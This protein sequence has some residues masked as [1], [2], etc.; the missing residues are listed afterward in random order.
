MIESRFYCNDC[1]IGF[2]AKQNYE[3]HIN[4]K[5][6]K[7]RLSTNDN[8]LHIC[9]KCQKKFIYAS[10]L[11]RHHLTC[12][13]K[14]VQPQIIVEMDTLQKENDE[15]R[16]EIEQLKNGHGQKNITNNNTTNN[17]DTQNIIN[18]NCFRNENMDYI[19]DKVILQCIC[20][21]YG[22]IPMIIEKIHFD[23]EHP[24]NNNVKIPNKKLP[25]AQIMTD[26]DKWKLVDRNDT[27]HSMIDNGYNLLDETFQEKGHV[28]SNKQQKHFKTFQTKYEDGDKNTIKDIKE[29][30]ELLVINNTR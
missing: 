9:L 8:N 5:K 1:H 23:P 19:T 27:I 15:L 2:N 28:L 20:K 10:G 26:N 7:N 25:H 4:T 24:E 3:Y 6:H 22:S 17:I 16:K 18:I 21:V 11:S 30:V 14:S 29:K 13:Y 12:K